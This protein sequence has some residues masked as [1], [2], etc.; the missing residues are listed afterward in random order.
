[1]PA[2]LH[3]YSGLGWARFSVAY[4]LIDKLESKLVLAYLTRL[5]DSAFGPN[6]SR[7]VI[8]SRSDSVPCLNQFIC[9]VFNAFQAAHNS[10]CE[11][12]IVG[13]LYRQSQC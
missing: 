7:T 1:M 8:A 10:G 2:Q 3:H 12:A 9:C 6:L 13:Q 4:N 5:C 11:L